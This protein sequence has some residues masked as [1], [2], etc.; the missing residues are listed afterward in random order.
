MKTRKSK[1]PDKIQQLIEAHRRLS[2]VHQ[3][4]T[5]YVPLVVVLDAVIYWDQ[6]YH[7]FH[8]VFPAKNSAKL[9]LGTLPGIV[10]RARQVQE[11]EAL[12]GKGL[13]VALRDENGEWKAGEVSRY[14]RAMSHFGG[15]MVVCLDNGEEIEA[16][17]YQVEICDDPAILDDINT[18]AK[19]AKW[20]EKQAEALQAKHLRQL[21]TRDK[22]SMEKAIRAQ[23]RRLRK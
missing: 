3:I 18:H 10:R 7:R 6:L 22:A 1:R 20:H 23:R 8:A 9:T 17:W 12:P 2:A 15:S 4:P 5:T 21:P 11:A 14:H 19:E 13:R 16:K